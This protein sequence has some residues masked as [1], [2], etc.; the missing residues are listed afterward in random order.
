MSEVLR[1]LGA[2]LGAVAGVA[3]VL[4]VLA[5]V[6]GL[7]RGELSGR[8]VVAAVIGIGLIALVARTVSVPSLL[9]GYSAVVYFILFAPIVVVV[10]YAFN[11]GRYA[12]VWDGFSTKWFGS[13]LDDEAITSSIGRSFRIGISTAIVS[14]VLGTAAALAIT[15]ARV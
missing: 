13:A 15:R 14:T 4:A 2:L 10:I 9:G 12:A 5:L 8:A 7:L 3:G 6:S 1:R 11:S